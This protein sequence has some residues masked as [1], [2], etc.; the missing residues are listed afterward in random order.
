MSTTSCTETGSGPYPYVESFRRT[1]ISWET[2]P[3]GSSSCMETTSTK[4]QVTSR[5]DNRLAEAD[6]KDL[7]GMCQWI[8]LAIYD[9]CVR[10]CWSCDGRLINT[11]FPIFSYIL[12][13][14][15]IKYNKTQK[16][17]NVAVI[18]KPCKCNLQFSQLLTFFNQ[19][20]KCHN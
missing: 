17:H 19:L 9:V 1:D 5:A 15:T 4:W 18:T 2:I 6:S 14:I 8:R 3:D 16:G 10:M 11:S 7:H 20:T 13:N 12:I